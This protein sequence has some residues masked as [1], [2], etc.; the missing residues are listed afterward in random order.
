MRE[1]SCGILDAVHLAL[2]AASEAVPPLRL[3]VVHHRNKID[4]RV[5]RPAIQHHLDGDDDPDRVA[6]VRVTD[7]DPGLLSHAR[8]RRMQDCRSRK[9]RGLHDIVLAPM[10]MVRPGTGPSGGPITHGR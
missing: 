7:S 3:K 4:R 5:S 10:R 9:R 2:N 8:Q 6:N 1:P